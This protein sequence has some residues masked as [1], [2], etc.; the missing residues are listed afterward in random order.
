MVHTLTRV[1]MP[2]PTQRHPLAGL[3]RSTGL[4][5]T[6]IMTVRYDFSHQAAG[7]VATQVR[8]APAVKPL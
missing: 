6:C 4:L 7:I 5:Q 3:W 8:H 1:D 2:V